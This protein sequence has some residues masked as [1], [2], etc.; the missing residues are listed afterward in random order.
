MFFADDVT[1]PDLYGPFWLCTTLILTMAVAGNMGAMFAFVPTTDQKVF[2][3]NFSKLSV[4]STLLY[5]YIAVIPL[6]GWA[7]SKWVLAAPFGLIDLVCIYGYAL[8]VL[9]PAAVICVIPLE[10]VR[11]LVMI[12]AFGVSVKFITRN[13]KDVVMR[14]VTTCAVFVVLLTSRQRKWGA[15]CVFKSSCFFICVFVLCIH[16]VLLLCGGR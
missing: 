15:V 11:W 2:L 8:T 7:V 12:L 10:I 5:G 3:Y 4:A 9:I 13:V 1:K 6:I 14:Q 16:N